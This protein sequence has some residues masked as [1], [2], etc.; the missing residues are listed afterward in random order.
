MAT[1]DAAQYVTG[2]VPI[3]R[4]GAFSG[5]FCDPFIED[6]ELE[7]GLLGPSCR[8]LS[9]VLEFAPSTVGE[10]AVTPQSLS[11]VSSLHDSPFFSPLGIISEDIS[12][13]F[14][15]ICELLLG[16]AQFDDDIRIVARDKD[17]DLF[18]TQVAAFRDRIQNLKIGQVCV[19]YFWC[20]GGLV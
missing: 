11:F 7:G 15:E 14:P 6:T 20:K 17:D 3:W 5:E 10:G 9:K 4:T 19:W 16:A 1:Q 2:A 12:K 13:S 18:L 8:V